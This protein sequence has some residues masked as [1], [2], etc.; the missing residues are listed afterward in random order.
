MRTILGDVAGSHYVVKSE[1]RLPTDLG[2]IINDILIR[3]IRRHPRRGE[4]GEDGGAARRH[5]ARPRRLQRH[6]EELLQEIQEG[7]RQ[8]RIRR[9]Q[10]RREGHRREVREVRLADGHQGGTVRPFMARAA[11]IPSARTREGAG[12]TERSVRQRGCRRASCEENCGKPMVL[13]RGRFGQFLACSGYP[14][15]KTTRKLISTQAGGLQAAKP[16]Q[17]ARGEKWPRCGSNL[18]IKQGRFGEFIAAPLTRRG[19][20]R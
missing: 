7:S 5:R 9:L 17:S 20:R 18:V 10:G 16:D 12:E 15:C 1:G 3:E 6:A 19:R 13:K 8:V 4:H 14:E 11:P 2:F